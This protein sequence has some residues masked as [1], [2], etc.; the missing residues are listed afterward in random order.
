MKAIISLIALMF[1]TMLFISACDEKPTEPVHDNPVDSLYDES[2]EE[3]NRAP[4]VPSN[5]SPDDGD[6]NVTLA[7]TLHWTSIDP[8]GDVI[9][10]D[11]YFSETTPPARYFDNLSQDSYELP[12]QAINTTFYWQIVARDAN[13]QTV[14]PVWSFTTGF[15]QQNQTPTTPSNPFPLDGS[16]NVN[17]QPT[18]S[19]SS[20][21]PDGDAVFYSILFSES[22]PPDLYV[23]DWTQ[24]NYALPPLAM[25]TTFYWQ[26]M[27]TDLSDFTLGPVWSFT[28]GTGGSGVVDTLIYDNNVWDTN[29]FNPGGHIGTRMS[30]GS[31]CQI[32]GL[33]YGTSRDGSTAFNAEIYGWSG[34]APTTA[35]HSEIATA[36]DGQWVYVDVEDE[37]IQV[38]SDFVI[39]FSAMGTE[40][41]PRII[42][43]FEGVSNNRAWYTIEG[44]WI[45]G[46]Q[47]LWMRTVVRYPGG[48]IVSL[49]PDGD[50]TF[51]VGDPVSNVDKVLNKSILLK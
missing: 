51:F 50:R 35:F 34:S 48:A 42:G 8:E 39:S 23:E 45:A 30:P 19:W 15:T 24:T 25:N 12:V 9:A 1:I 33:L 22:T 3:E 4:S 5:P 21:D 36:F 14:G 46:D 6:F 43:T 18:L 28:T 20:G 11:L 47:T 31:Q 10:Y 7:P 49:S 13:H 2:S 44:D 17:T 27:A 41:S 40:E 26:V 38:N 37:D 32:L 16:F 29:W